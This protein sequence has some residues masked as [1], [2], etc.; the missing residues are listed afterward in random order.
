MPQLSKKIAESQ[1]LVPSDAFDLPVKVLQ[2]G[3]GVLLRGLCDY[4]IDKA[5]RAGVFGGRVVV[6]KSTSGGVGND[7][8]TNQDGLYTVVTQGVQ[9][10]KNVD[11]ATVVSAISRVISAQE[12]WDD[13]LKIARNP[14]LEI[15]ISNTTEVGIQYVEES[16]FKG[17]P[18]SFPAKLTRF[19]YERFKMFGGHKNK[20][21]IVVPTE[22]I[23]DNG[24]KLRECVEKIS[25]ANQLGGMFTKWLKY[26]VKFCNSLVDRIVPG[27]P[28]T[29]VHSELETRLGY[30]DALLTVTEPYHFWA[31]EGDDRVKQVLSFAAA[32]PESIVIEEDITFYRE[33]KLRILNGSHSLAAQLGFLNGFDT[34]YECTQDA[35][36]N[37]FYDA[38]IYQNIIPTLPFEDQNEAVIHFAREV[39]DRYKNPYIKHKLLGI[40]LQA[41]SKMNARNVPTL[42]R[43][44][45][46][47]DTVPQQIAQGFAAFLLFEKSVK[48]ENGQYFGLRNNEFYP[49]NDD[50][51]AYFYTQWAK[52]DSAK[53]KEFVMEILGNTQLWDCDLNKFDGFADAVA[54]YLSTQMK[55]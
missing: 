43:Y 1:K 35:T 33:R 26:H 8:F 42:Q 38:L 40:T 55:P 4:Q 19:L 17:P 39:L 44:Y 54:G 23:T 10:G 3:T 24:L 30:E 12:N 14:H 46:E 13:I 25:K 6:V 47:F 34:V 28:A 18:T 45:D 52:F 16:V 5:N 37:A 53:T 27:K 21:L 7:D 51:T 49:I 31:I 2:F 41:T 9:Q 36:M 50:A 32:N 15:I 48:F 22:L 20:G 11:E 29:A